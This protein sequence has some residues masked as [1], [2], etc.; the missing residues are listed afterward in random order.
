MAI[1]FSGYWAMAFAM[2]GGILLAMGIGLLGRWLLGIPAAVLAGRCAASARRGAR[3]HRPGGEPLAHGGAGDAD[4]AGDDAGR[5]PGR[6]GVQQPAPHRGRLRRPR[7]R[8]H[9]V[10]GA[11]ARRC[12]RAPPA[13]SPGST[14]STASRPSCRPR[15][16]RAAGARRPEPVAGRRAERH[17][18]TSTLD[19]DVVQGSLATSA[20]TRSRS[21]ACSPPRATW[22]RRRG[23]RPDG[24]HRRRPRCGSR[25]STTGR[26]ASATSCS[27][28]PS[29]AATRRSRPTRPCSSPAA[30]QPS[31]RSSATRPATGRGAAQPRRLPR[32]AARL[33]RR[34]R[35]GR[36]ARR[37]ARDRL[38]G[39]RAD[40]HGGDDH[41]GAPRRARDAS[42]CS[43]APPVTPCG[44][45]RSRC[46]RRWP[47]DWA[48][49]RRSSRSPSPAC[50]AGDG[51]PAR[52]AAR[53]RRRPGR[54]RR[55]S[56]ACSPPPSR[57]DSRDASRRR[58]PCADG[59]EDHAGAGCGAAVGTAAWPRTPASG[60]SPG[61]RRSTSS[62]PASATTA[63]AVRPRP[64]ASVNARPA[65]SAS[66]WPAGPPTRSATAWAAPTDSPRRVRRAAHLA[67]V[68]R[69]DD[70]PD[71]GDA[72]RAADLPRHVAH[73]RPDSAPWPRAPRSSPSR[74]RAPSP[75]PSRA[76]ARRSRDPGAAEPCPAS[77]RGSCSARARRRS[78]RRR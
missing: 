24:R 69:A 16:T 23:S 31:D 13:R 6:R 34:R 77:R 58:R 30:R 67:R 27:T 39:P 20:A 46:S 49:E 47:S 38:R 42:A 3:R 33:E 59:T 65:V 56:S 4:R 53:A 57:R 60:R 78:G 5:H 74:W 43:A 55:C 40:Q 25:R 52:R 76:R 61:R 17:A 18:A 28:R 22:D 45:W 48:R 9:V 70:R 10:V 21:A 36:L 1:V 62:A 8:A 44:W 15:S 68:G 63:A 32:H 2:L 37:R 73:R 14:A 54:R 71:D 64:S 26:R 66:S 50:R 29:P 72:E 75:S 12:R 51:L 35:V 7:A 11:A 41:D 19:P